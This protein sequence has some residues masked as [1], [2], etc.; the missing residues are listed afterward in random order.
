[1]AAKK[2]RAKKKSGKGGEKSISSSSPLLWS[3][4]DECAHYAAL[5]CHI[6]NVARCYDDDNLGDG[7]SIDFRKFRRR[8]VRRH[9][10]LRDVYPWAPDDF[11]PEDIQSVPEVAMDD[12]DM[13][14]TITNTSETTTNI[15]YVTVYDVDLLD[16]KGQPLTMGAAVTTHALARLSPPLEEGGGWNFSKLKQRKCT[17]FV[18]SCPPRTFIELCSLVPYRQ[19]YNPGGGRPWKMIDSWSHVEIETDV[20]PITQHLNPDDEHTYT[21]HFPFQPEEGST[22]TVRPCYQC[23]Q[24]EDGELTHFF[25]GN[26]HAID[27]A[28]PIGTPLYSPVDGT[29]INVRDNG[30]GD[31]AIAEGRGM[32]GIFG[33]RGSF[34][35]DNS[36]EDYGDV[37]EVTGIAARNMFRWNSIMIRVD[38]ASM[39]HDP[40]FVEFVHIQTGSCVVETG[41]T[42]RKGQL[43][44][45]S[46]SVGFSPEPH[47]HMAAYRSDGDDAA[48]VRFRFECSSLPPAASEEDAAMSTEGNT[49]G[50]RKEEVV[51]TTFLPTTGGWYDC[52]GLVRS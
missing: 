25:K 12:S 26:R 1:M 22:V 29:V 45:R 46:G 13:T 51:P 37:I 6:A 42:V 24:S 10:W 34:V 18:V 15:C 5:G 40:L 11:D 3:A 38:D 36:I 23:T 2:G 44:C 35:H 28:C 9:P 41:T 27:F 30:G 20:Q 48:T 49:A 33:N 19:M 31:V 39:T 17:T 8:A 4:A 16:G 7:G 21:M 52:G 32:N 43:I 47:L 50:N 14:L